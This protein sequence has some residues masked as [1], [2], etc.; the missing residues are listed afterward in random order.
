MK[1]F[2]AVFFTLCSFSFIYAQSDAEFQKYFSKVNTVK[3]DEKVPISFILTLDTDKSGNLLVSEKSGVFL[4]DKNGKLIKQLNSDECSPGIKWIF[5]RAIYMQNGE[6]YMMNSYPGG[7]RFKNNGSCIKKLDGMV[8]NTLLTSSFTD[9]SIINAN[10]IN[11]AQYAPFNVY[12]KE[13]KTIAKF[14]KY[15]TGLDNALKQ[16]PAG[17]SKGGLVVDGKDIVYHV[18][19]YNAE[20]IKYDKSG[21]QLGKIFRK[22][23]RY[24]LLRDDMPKIDPA[25]IDLNDKKSMQRLEEQFNKYFVEYTF[26]KN[27]FLLDSE[28]LLLQYTFREISSIQ[29]FSTN[30][31]YLLSKDILLDK[32]S[33]NNR[34][35]LMMAKNGYLYFLITPD[36]KKNKDASNPYIEV[37]KYKGKRN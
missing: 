36:Y 1:L 18:P 13:G 32:T 30:G 15:I 8:L 5:P 26:S 6:I 10:D 34:S 23:D 9:G 7:V 20:I 11:L 16:I 14:G 27:L 29:I 24:F 22:P 37:Y 28:L 35:E 2:A 21:K 3:L 12:S 33:G 31:N 17:G 19:F 4:F 25:K